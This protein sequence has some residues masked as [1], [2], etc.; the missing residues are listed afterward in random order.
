MLLFPH[1]RDYEIE[2]VINKRTG[3]KSPKLDEKSSDLS[4]GQ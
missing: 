3:P 2:V 4:E 1:N